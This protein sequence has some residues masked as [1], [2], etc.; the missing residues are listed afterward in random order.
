V[1]NNDRTRVMTSLSV[2]SISQESCQLQPSCAGRLSDDDFTVGARVFDAT[3][4][5][6][7]LDQL[8]AVANRFSELR[9]L[10]SVSLV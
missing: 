8:V 6:Y 9:D 1:V 2:L 10:T 3:T 4:P 7:N 5:P